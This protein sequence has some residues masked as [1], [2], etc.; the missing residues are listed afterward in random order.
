MRVVQV[1]KPKAPLTL[2]E[3]PTEPGAGEV[4][5]KIEV[6]GICH[7][8]STYPAVR[9]PAVPSHEIVGR[10]RIAR[11]DRGQSSP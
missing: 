1:E 4:R 3:R 2:V 6:C 7:S 11:R 8:D 9:H 5:I 10:Q